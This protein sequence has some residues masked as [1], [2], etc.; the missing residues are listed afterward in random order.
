MKTTVTSR[1]QTV[2]PAQI[3]KDH[4]IEQQTRLEWID[5]GVTIRVVPVS[6]DP[7]R[8]ARGSS[9]GLGAALLRERER[10]RERARG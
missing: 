4:H 9:Q 1:G 10:E 5:D 8:A 6:E 7:V 3:R 2:V